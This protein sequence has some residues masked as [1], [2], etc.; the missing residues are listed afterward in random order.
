MYIP[1]RRGGGGGRRERDWS[2]TELCIIPQKIHYVIEGINGLHM[3]NELTT[4]G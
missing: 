2:G 1:E 4:I 3:C